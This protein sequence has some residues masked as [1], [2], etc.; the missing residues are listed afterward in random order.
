MRNKHILVMIAGI[1]L[2]F[3]ALACNVPG[4]GTSESRLAP[5][6]QP[7]LTATPSEETAIEPTPSESEAIPTATDEVFASPIPTTA[8]EPE[9]EPGRITFETGATSVKVEGTVAANGIDEYLLFALEGQTMTVTIRSSTGSVYVAVT[10]LADG[11]PLVRSAAEQTSW[12]GLLPAS[13]DYSIKAVSTGEE[14]SY[15]MTITIPPVDSSGSGLT[16]DMLRNG[17]YVLMGS[18]PHTLVDGRFELEDPVSP[19]R[20]QMIDLMGFGDLDADGDLD[21]AVIIVTNTGGTGNFYEL[22]IVLNDNGQPLN[23]A[24]TFLEDRIIVNSILIQGNE[25]IMDLIVHD[26]D[27]PFCCPSLATTVRFAWENGELVYL[28][29]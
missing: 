7:T 18:G 4:G 24:S 3:A 14:A 20:S 9:A 17:S 13:Q 22:F 12:T 26:E 28:E 8:P 1:F 11:N 21:A 23:T 19:I 5:A 10:G 2:C 15:M 6:G 27:D 25:I 16:V 29:G